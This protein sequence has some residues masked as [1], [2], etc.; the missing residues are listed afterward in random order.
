[1]GA[2]PRVN[3][4]TPIQS[5][6]GGFMKNRDGS[7]MSHGDYVGHAIDLAVEFQGMIDLEMA[8]RM[9]EWNSEG[10]DAVWQEWCCENTDELH[11]FI[12]TQPRKRMNEPNWKNPL[13]F[14]RLAYGASCICEFA[15]RRLARLHWIAIPLPLSKRKMVSLAGI[16]YLLDNSCLPICNWDRLLRLYESLSKASSPLA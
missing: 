3:I 12:I 11:D 4:E 7:P 5:Q 9:M 16:S 14:G 15:T 2:L 6:P 13:A 1:V 8:C 10:S